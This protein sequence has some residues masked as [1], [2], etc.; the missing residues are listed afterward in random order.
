MGR[1]LRMSLVQPPAQSRVSYKVRGSYSEF[2]PAESQKPPRTETTQPL[3]AVC[4]MPGY[5]YSEK[6][7]HF[8]QAGPLLFQFIPFCLSRTHHST[9]SRAWSRLLHNLPTYTEGLLLGLPKPSL[10]WTSQFPQPFFTGQVLQSSD[11]PG[12][13][14]MSLLHLSY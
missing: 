14:T 10:L 8:I 1:D 4:P 6:V 5:P 11:Y 12:G 3:W 9:L 2:Y 13:L 7:F